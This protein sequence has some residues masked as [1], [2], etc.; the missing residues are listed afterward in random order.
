MNER[1]VAYINLD[2]IRNSVLH[3][4]KQLDKEVKIM[5]V[6]KA[7]AY[8]HGA[9]KVA[10]S[11][12]DIVDYIAVATLKEGIELRRH[13]IKLPILVLGE[14]INSE[15]RKALK[16]Q[17]CATV[18][19]EKIMKNFISYAIMNKIII[20]IHVAVDTGMN[21]IGIQYD[22]PEIIYNVFNSKYLEVKGIFTHLAKADDD[23]YNNFQ[24]GNFE[25][26]ISYLLNKGCKIP[27]MHISNSL[28][29]LYPYLNMDCVRVGITQ[30]VP[31]DKRFPPAMT[32]KAKI[33]QIKTL[34]AEEKVGYDCSYTAKKEIKMATISI[35]YADGLMRSLSNKGYVIANGKKADIIGKIC[36]DYTMIDITGIENVKE[37][38]YVTVFGEN[39]I[40]A[41]IVAES[42][43]TISYEVL[44]NISD[45]VKRIYI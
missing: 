19:S 29:L 33:I 9:V 3:I 45:R 32:L 21:R 17:I 7:N 22:N 24:Y 39:E 18:Y 10:E 13:N 38:D 37:G 11:I 23:D 5:S 27:M 41:E 26:V 28:G 40:T 20:P 42:A 8:G 25:N 36:M 1:V 43:N 15:I 6:L 14:I 12:Q 35:G 4:R 34:K 30:F 44:T 31:L 16:Y 2:N